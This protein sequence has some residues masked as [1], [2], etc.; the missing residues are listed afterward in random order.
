MGQTQLWADPTQAGG[1]AGNSHQGSSA[2]I[3]LTTHSME[4]LNISMG[5][6]HKQQIMSA[7]NSTLLAAP[8]QRATAGDVCVCTHGLM[9]ALRFSLGMGRRVPEMEVTAL[10]NWNCTSNA[11]RSSALKEEIMCSRTRG[12][13][14]HSAFCKD[15]R[16]T[17]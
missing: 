5:M 4:A 15:A 1:N 14:S 12:T 8:R 3:A 17:Q 11:A 9:A 6:G 16:R 13:M 2:E 10:K 7:K